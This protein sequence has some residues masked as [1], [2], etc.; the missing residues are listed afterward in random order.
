[1]FLFKRVGLGGEE[2]QFA[3]G[4]LQLAE[5]DLGVPGIVNEDI[6]KA[7]AGEH[8]VNEGIAADCYVWVAPDEVASW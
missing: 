6:F 7:T 8:I 3:V 4:S 5:C 1:M 2:E